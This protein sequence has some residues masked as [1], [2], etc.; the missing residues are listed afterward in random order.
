MMAP[1]VS[2]V[3]VDGAAAAS[4]EGAAVAADGAEAVPA[5][6]CGVAPAAAPATDA[7]A[8]GGAAG[9]VVVGGGGGVAGAGVAGGFVVVTGVGVDGRAGG[10]AVVTACELDALGAGV[11]VA[12]EDEGGGEVASTAPVDVVAGAGAAWPVLV[13]NAAL[14]APELAVALVPAIGPT[15]AAADPEAHTPASRTRTTASTWERTCRARRLGLPPRAASMLP[16]TIAIPT[17]RSVSPCGG[18][19]PRPRLRNAG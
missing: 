15:A 10:G 4:H 6:D 3:A 18:A 11:V 7:A 13:D 2:V 1:A 9:V 19:P 17:S 5:E 12:G 16:E 8:Q 14:V